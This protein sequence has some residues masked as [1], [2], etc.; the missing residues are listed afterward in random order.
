CGRAASRGSRASSRPAR[1]SPSRPTAATTSKPCGTSVPP[2]DGSAAGNGNGLAGGSLQTQVATKPIPLH[3]VTPPRPRLQPA[4]APAPPPHRH[5]LRRLRLLVHPL[6][7]SLALVA[8]A[9]G[10]LVTGKILAFSDIAS[11]TLPDRVQAAR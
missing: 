10:Q 5:P 2:K 7:A 8:V 9:F 1:S 4:P 6:T 3:V 11:Y